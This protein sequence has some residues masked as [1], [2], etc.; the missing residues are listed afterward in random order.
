MLARGLTSDSDF[1]RFLPLILPGEDAEGNAN[2]VQGYVG[3]YGFAAFFG[4]DEGTIFDGTVV[5]LREVSLAYSLP[6]SLLEKT[7]FG[8]I[9]LRLAGEN[10]WY[11]APNFPPGVNF[12][13][14]VLSLGVG[15][16]RGFD[17]LTGPTA[18]K[19]GATLSLTF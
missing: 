11:N 12:D 18:K 7:P 19:I 9:S 17:Y 15:N 8:S 5:R 14:E 2:T 13:P 3:D 1:D 10:L 16:G 4:A 6:A